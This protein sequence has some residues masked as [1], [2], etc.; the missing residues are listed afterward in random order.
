[1]RAGYP[2]TAVGA[3]KKLHPSYHSSHVGPRASAPPPTMLL[4]TPPVRYNAAATAVLRAEGMAPIARFLSMMDSSSLHSLISRGVAAGTR[5][6]WVANVQE[7]LQAR[8]ARPGAGQARGRQRGEGAAR[9]AWVHSRP[10]RPGAKRYNDTSQARPSHTCLCSTSVIIII[11]RRSGINPIS[12]TVKDRDYDTKQKQMEN[13]DYEVL[14]LH[15]RLHNKILIFMVVRKLSTGVTISW[16]YYRPAP[17]P[18]PPLVLRTRPLVPCS[19]PFLPAP[20]PLLLLLLLLHQRCLTLRPGLNHL[21][22]LLAK[23]RGPATPVLTLCVLTTSRR[24]VP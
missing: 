19:F 2:W 13:I 7:H 23:G 24:W 10:G 15:L 22:H 20:P 17:Q 16:A 5:W 3:G 12:P 1:M 21:P 18:P 4:Q 11:K 6:G 14:T 8:Q 9:H